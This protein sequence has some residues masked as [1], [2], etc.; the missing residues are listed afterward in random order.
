MRLPSQLAVSALLL[1]DL[2]TKDLLMGLPAVQVNLMME[3]KPPRLPDMTLDPNKPWEPHLST[4]LNQATQVLLIHL[5]DP[6]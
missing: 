3:I 6:S 4:L 2:E 5:Q 1:Q